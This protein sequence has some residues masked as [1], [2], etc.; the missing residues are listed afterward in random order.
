L[1]KSRQPLDLPKEQ[2]G[3]G[4]VR[5]SSSRGHEPLD[6]GSVTRQL[7]DLTGVAQ[8][9]NPREQSKNPKRHRDTEPSEFRKSG[10]T[11]AEDRE[12]P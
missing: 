5:S 1:E 3:Y 11:R 12:F 8:G 9:L 6:R 7:S 10:F 4:C 2:G